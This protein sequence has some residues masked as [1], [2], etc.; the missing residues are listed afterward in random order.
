CEIITLSNSSDEEELDKLEN[1]DVKPPTMQQI[2]QSSDELLANLHQDDDNACIGKISLPPLKAFEP[3]LP[4]S[5]NQS[6]PIQKKNTSI[7][8][9]SHIN[10]RNYQVGFKKAI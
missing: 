4:P 7:M 2:V 5:F 1:I 6:T 3:S 8:N 9:Q 10:T